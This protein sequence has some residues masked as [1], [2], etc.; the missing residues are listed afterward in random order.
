[1]VLLL[2]G[3]SVV[4]VLVLGIDLWCGQMGISSL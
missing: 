3:G 2:T 1:V 4:M